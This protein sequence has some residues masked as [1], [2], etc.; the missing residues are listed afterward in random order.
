MLACC[1]FP[2]ATCTDKHLHVF[3]FSIFC[4]SS[5]SP[6]PLFYYSKRMLIIASWI[7]SILTAARFPTILECSTGLRA[8]RSDSTQSCTELQWSRHPLLLRLHRAVREG[9]WARTETWTGPRPER[10]S[11][12]TA[13][14]KGATGRDKP[15]TKSRAS[16]NRWTVTLAASYYVLP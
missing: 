1:L 9:L 6:Q 4:S 10:G 16:G 3:S 12:M 13:R 8:S 2:W 14:T 7:V 11:V 5:F 15:E